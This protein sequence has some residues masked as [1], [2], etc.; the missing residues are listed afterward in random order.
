MKKHKKTELKVPAQLERTTT[1]ITEQSQVPKSEDKS[2]KAGQT[3]RKR[4][5]I[6]GSEPLCQH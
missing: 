2:E 4:D 5:R 6:S 3:D 1:D